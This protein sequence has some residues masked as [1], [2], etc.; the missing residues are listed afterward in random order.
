VRFCTYNEVRL[1]TISA[2]SQHWVKKIS[3]TNSCFALHISHFRPR[4]LA[5]GAI[6]VG[7]SAT[8]TAQLDPSPW[9]RDGATVGRRLKAN[10]YLEEGAWGAE[11]TENLGD[12][13]QRLLSEVRET[14]YQHK[15][16]I[17][18]AAGVCDVD[19]SGLVDYLLKQIAPEKFRQLPV[20]SGH[21]RPRAAMYF[22]FLDRLRQQPLPGWE[23][24]RQLGDA[25]RGDII[26]WELEP[27][28]QEPGDTGHVVIVAAAPVL[29]TKDFFRV[30]VYDSSGIHHDDDSRP[31]HTSGVGEGIITFR[32]NE[33]GEPIA[34]QFNSRAHFHTEPIA[35]GRLSVSR[36]HRVDRDPGYGH[37]QPD[38]KRP[39]G[40]PS[41]GREAAAE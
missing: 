16:N 20:E 8:Q 12:A 6:L 26:A 2:A 38:W 9:N 33:R 31:E 30:E 39:T 5:I 14:H 25:R 40:E 22:Q 36:E 19:C 32:V 23:A 24:V 7:A 34:F 17:D 10:I 11:N 41:M 35:I 4:A 29:E 3:H 15:T 1:A 13:A 28:T 37:I 27:S 21:P 18:R